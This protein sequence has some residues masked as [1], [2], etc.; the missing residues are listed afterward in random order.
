MSHDDARYYQ[1]RAEAELQLAQKARH[2]RVV[3]AHY[4]L[5]N[6][7]LDRAHGETP[8]KAPGLIGI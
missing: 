1:Q 4:D 2:Q 7:Y 5:A 6:A 8:V 3:Q